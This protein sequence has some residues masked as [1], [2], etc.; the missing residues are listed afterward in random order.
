MA[1]RVLEIWRWSVR[2]FGRYFR[3]TREGAKIV[4]LS[5]MGCRVHSK[6]LKPFFAQVNIEITRGHQR[7]NLA[8][9]HISSEM[10]HY[11]RIYYRYQATEKKHSIAHSQVFRKH[12][13]RNHPT[14]TSY[15]TEV[16]KCQN[17][18][19]CE[20]K[21]QIT[22]ELRAL[23]TYIWLKRVP[24]VESRRNMHMLPLKG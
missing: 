3:K 24:L 2:N 15:G 23:V 20:K 19:F 22:F 21:S 7:S 6:A 12:A 18:F 13:I 10:C 8:E 17:S 16:K 5:G 11:H 14:T 9:C 4:L 1:L